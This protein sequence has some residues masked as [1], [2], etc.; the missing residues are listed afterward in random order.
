MDQSVQLTAGAE[1]QFS[2]SSSSSS[3]ISG[4]RRADADTAVPDVA[5]AP[6]D[7]TDDPCTPVFVSDLLPGRGAFFNRR[8]SSVA[9]SC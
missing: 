5:L 8:S 7:D 3:C 4:I 9:S 1:R 6:P 2:L